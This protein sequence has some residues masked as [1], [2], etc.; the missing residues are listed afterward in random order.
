MKRPAQSIELAAFDAA[1]EGYPL[2]VGDEQFGAVEILGVL[3]GE[4]A[5]A[6]LEGAGD[7]GD[8]DA[9]SASIAAAATFTPYGIGQVVLEN[10]CSFSTPRGLPWRFV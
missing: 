10:L 3:Y 8:L 6:E 9:V 1:D 2:A 7:D 5:V 4:Q